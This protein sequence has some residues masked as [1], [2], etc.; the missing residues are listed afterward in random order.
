M[1]KYITTVQ[2][3]VLGSLFYNSKP[4]YQ[5]GYNMKNYFLKMLLVIFLALPIFAL[6]QVAY[7]D[8]VAND[9]VQGTSAASL[10][11]K[12][13]ADS[14][15][16][17]ISGTE[18]LKGPLAATST[19]S[20]MDGGT[21]TSGKRLTLGGGI[22]LTSGVGLPGSI[23]SEGGA[24][25]ESQGDSDLKAVL[26]GAGYTSV[27]VTGV[28]SLKFDFTVPAGISSVN[29]DFLFASQETYTSDWDIAGVFVD[30]VNYAKLPNGRILRVT[31]ASELNN[32]YSSLLSGWD[33]WAVPQTVV[34]LL[35]LT[36]TTHTIKIAVADTDDQLV[37]SGLFLSSL[38]TSAQTGGGGGIVPISGSSVSPPTALAGAGGPAFTLNYAAAAGG[39]SNGEI[40][41]T[42]P[43]GWSGGSVTSSTGAPSLAGGVIKVTG[44]TLAEGATITITYSGVTVGATVG[45]NIF[46]T[47]VKSNIDGTLAA[48]V[49]SPTVTV[50]VN[51]T[52]SIASSTGS[53]GI[54]GQSVTFTATVAS[55][56]DTP[57]GTVV[58]QDG[59][60]TLGSA[61]LNN[62]VA[63]YSISTL[64]VGS[65][66]IKAIYNGDG[67]NNGSN[68][69][70]TINIVTSD[71]TPAVITWANPG[72]I[73]YGTAL[74]TA[75]LNATANVAGTFTYTPA[76]GTVLPVG[77]HTLSV[78][79]TPN[80]TVNYK[81]QSATTTVTVIL[82]DTIAPEIAKLSMP[83]TNSSLSVVITEL[84]ATDAFGVTGY[85][86]SDNASPPLAS[87]PAW[88]ANVPSSY[89][90]R[91]WGNNTLYAFAKDAAGN[92]S[93]PKTALVYI[94]AKP[95]VD[96][97]MIPAE[98]K[99]VPDIT[100]ALKSLNFAMKLET[101]TEAQILHGNVAPL[102]D[103]IP[104]PDGVIN[105]GDTI[106]IL[107]RVVG[108]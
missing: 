61:P 5:E 68:A 35:D 37:P 65:H 101:P 46:T 64:T 39:M 1:I 26:D 58:F 50:K 59:S 7:S 73:S 83:S 43:A 28:N 55:S 81:G 21:L 32:Y 75:Q 10:V 12:L 86:L 19:Y 77:T 22:A 53:S 99:T 62:G 18:V 92:I 66:T 89:I 91:T 79:F 52:T 108:L 103:G 34:G 98:G 42:V 13:V 104:Q 96:G 45:A 71:T 102:I 63:V 57:V 54:L 11:S 9:F 27:V 95:G 70:T 100:D 33:S 107:R 29:L 76:S 23:T 94:G 24:F 84:I 14:A 31:T 51:S 40:N 30:G 16:T 69:S 85:L 20:A 67:K 105:L 8:I 60:V 106:V 82:T 93:T 49:N 74:S 44:V 48:L 6:P 47:A 2:N 72:S 4:P 41:V 90:F 78:A 25:S 15:I 87:D 36:K 17:V 97:V 88:S 56:S 38:R 80:D 3:E